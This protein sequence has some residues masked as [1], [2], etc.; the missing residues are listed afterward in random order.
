MIDAIPVMVRRVATALAVKHYADRFRSHADHPMVRANAE[1]NW[2]MFADEAATVIR[3]IRE[4]TEEMMRSPPIGGW[5]CG[6]GHLPE[7]AGRVWRMMVD[8]ALK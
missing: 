7:D 3:A 1:G 8:E 2:R 5:S 4:P 6:Y